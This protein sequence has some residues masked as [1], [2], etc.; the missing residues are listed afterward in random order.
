MTDLQNTSVTL[1]LF[2]DAFAGHKLDSTRG[3][4]VILAPRI[5]PARE[6]GGGFT[7]T[8]NNRDDL[9]LLGERR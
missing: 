9:T 1:L 2:A 8:V 4:Y 3:V 6:G 7:M 5:L